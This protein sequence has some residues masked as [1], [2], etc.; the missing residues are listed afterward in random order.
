MDQYLF[1]DLYLSLFQ[2]S[3]HSPIKILNV[4]N[5][6]YPLSGQILRIFV[7]KCFVI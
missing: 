1:R 6:L 3:G 4:M 2:E 7:Y 5:Q